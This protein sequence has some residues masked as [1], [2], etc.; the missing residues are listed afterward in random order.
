MKKSI[1]TTVGLSLAI[2][3]G[4][5]G[6]KD[7]I[8]GD[9]NIVT[10]KQELQPFSQISIVGMYDVRLMEGSPGYELTIDENLHAYVLN[11][12]EGNKVTIGSVDHMLDADSAV[13]K[14]YFEDLNEI[15]INGACK[16]SSDHVF[17]EV[18]NVKINGASKMQLALNVSSSHFELNGGAEIELSGQ[19]NKLDLELNG[20]AEVSAFELVTDETHISIMGAG[21]VETHALKRLDVSIKGAG[22]VE[23][24]GDPEVTQSIM[25]AGEVKQQGKEKQASETKQAA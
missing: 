20:A 18:L 12:M 1:L 7:T 23:Y 9:G 15:E 16:L 11:E 3:I 25:G 8:K 14:I 2:L 22:N 10:K 19:A 21:E 4:L 17:D 13:L 24:I 5:A 6:C